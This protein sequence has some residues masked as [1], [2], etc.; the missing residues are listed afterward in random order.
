MR[1]AIIADIHGNLDALNAVLSD[2]HKESVDR[3]IAN[4]DMVNRGP[5]NSAV[6]ELLNEIGASITLGNHD[7]LMVKWIDHDPS[8][9]ESFFQDPIWCATGWCARQL[10][11]AGL[12]DSL[13]WLPKSLSIEPKGGQRVLICHG[14][15]RDYR[16]GIGL[17]MAD[18]KIRE[19][20][21]PFNADVYVG[22][23]THRPM[24][25]SSG[26]KIVINT[27]SVGAP[28]DSDLRAQYVIMTCSQGIWDIEFRRVTYDRESAM[29]AF[30]TTGF[31]RDGGL[32]ACIFLAELRHARSFLVPFLKWCSKGGVP[33]TEASWEIFQET[34]F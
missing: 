25:R 19:I 34:F 30:E 28:F 32:S 2:A 9:S 27:G 7:D 10:D 18:T 24:E 5:N 14:S 16:E 22:S 1:I 13:R 31:L 23:H 21:L 11:A 20:I 6:V 12:I 15:P 26:R 3:I 4:G 33:S 8:L 29:E 17:H